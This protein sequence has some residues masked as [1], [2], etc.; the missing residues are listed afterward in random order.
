VFPWSATFP[1]A[2]TETWKEGEWNMILPF[3]DD[4]DW[5]AFASLWSSLRFPSSKFV[6]SCGSVIFRELFVEIAAVLSPTVMTV[7]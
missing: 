2:V 5:R 3:D 4:K 1:W 6:I 7:S